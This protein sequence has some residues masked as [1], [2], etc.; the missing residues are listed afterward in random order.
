MKLQTICFIFLLISSSPAA[1]SSE[2]HRKTDSLH[3][4]LQQRNTVFEGHIICQIGSLH[5]RNFQFKEGLKMANEALVIGHNT[6]NEKLII[7]AHRLLADIYYAMAEYELSL[8]H[9]FIELEYH[10]KNGNLRKI[11]EVH[12]NIGVVY[13]VKGFVEKGLY[14]YLRALRLYE[15]VDDKEGLVATL[16]NLAHIYR[17]QRNYAEA[18]RHFSMAAEIEREFLDNQKPHY[19]L[20]NIGEDYMHMKEYERAAV[21]LEEADSML[22]RLPKPDDEDLLIWTDKARVQGII[23]METGQY[24]NALEYFTEALNI[25]RQT[26]YLEKEGPVLIL[27]GSLL[28]ETGELI[29]AKTYL[30]QAQS[31]AIE[32]GSFTMQRDVYKSLSMLSEKLGMY[33]KALEYFK[34]FNQANDSVINIESARRMS[35]MQVTFETEKKE[36]Q[37]RLLQQENEIQH[38]LT[39]KSENQ[40]RLAVIAAVALL[41]IAGLYFNRYRLKKQSAALLSEKNDQLAG[42]NATKDKFFA[43]L[44]HDLKNPVSSFSNI[45]TLLKDKLEYLNEND[46]RY[47][48]TEMSN[49]AES[50]NQ[51]LL[52]LLQ[53]ARSQRNQLNIE[54]KEHNTSDLISKALRFLKTET[55][56]KQL[57]IHQNKVENITLHTDDNIMITL[58]RNVIGNAV[59]FSPDGSEISVTASKENGRCIISVCDMGPG[60]QAED[61][62]KLFRTDVNTRSIGNHSA[63][64]TGLGLILCSELLEKIGGSI[65]AE[66]VFGQ[67][68]TFFIEVPGASIHSP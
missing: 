43:I 14:H 3:S 65:R 17:E 27:L 30:E 45:S 41:L 6:Q 36:A 49:S 44:A 2:Y 18:I 53:W 39:Q 26:G 37:I 25:V 66:S 15:L 64:G 23:S 11:A 42:L 35:E 4:F 40:R 60:M 21:I 29:S 8:K 67:G 58:L 59:K 33:S 5:Y 10:K 63:K 38:L 34:L 68:S 9:F 46:L 31:I 12:C 22:R 20:V 19:F 54:L 50:L 56:L 48:L 32:T 16:S 24:K 51:L 61:I 52:N 55:D 1:K 28:T 13:D 7:R 47:Y 62:E 57:T